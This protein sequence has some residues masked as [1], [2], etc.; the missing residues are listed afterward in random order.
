M[1][2]LLND[3]ANGT[4]CCFN[5][6]LTTGFLFEFL[7]KKDKAID[8]IQLDLGEPQHNQCD[9]TLNLSAAVAEHLHLD[10]VHGGRI[11][12]LVV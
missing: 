8:I 9:Y 4:N 12:C 5:C 6:L 11:V 2:L 1:L 3:A 7:C 10:M